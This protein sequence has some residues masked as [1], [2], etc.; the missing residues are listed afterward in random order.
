VCF[1]GLTIWRPDLF[2]LFNGSGIASIAR[3]EL[4][5]PIVLR[6]IAVQSFVITVVLLGIRLKG[7]AMR[8]D[9]LANGHEFQFSL[10]ALMILTGASA[11]AIWLAQLVRSRVDSSVTVPEVLGI[12]IFSATGAA[13]ALLAVWVALGSSKVWLRLLILGIAT[14]VLGAMPPYVCHREQDLGAMISWACIHAVLVAGSLLVLRACGYRLAR[15]ARVATPLSAGKTAQ[16]KLL[17]TVEK[18]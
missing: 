4:L 3:W 10:R 2:A 14:L 7:F 12:G 1:V 17:A 11:V 16:K 9:D 18:G 6:A 5:L 13:N 8:R 15:A